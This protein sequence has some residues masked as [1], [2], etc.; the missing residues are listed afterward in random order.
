MEQK[1]KEEKATIE[2]ELK[3]EMEKKEDEWFDEKC[4]YQT[5]EQDFNMKI[6]NHKSEMDKKMKALNEEKNKEIKDL[7]IIISDLEKV[8]D[9]KI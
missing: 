9:G 4:G 5:R 7:K 6:V 3:K 1:H 8:R 2:K